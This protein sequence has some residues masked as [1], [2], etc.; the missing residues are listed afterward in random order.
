MWAGN[1]FT[2]RG[3]VHSGS[4]KSQ[5]FASFSALE[6][7]T[8]VPREPKELRGLGTRAGGLGS[9][10]VGLAPALCTLR[11]GP[12]VYLAPQ[13]FSLLAPRIL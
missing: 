7:L 2:H 8:Q 9:Q 3:R 13:T 1:A 6:V 10:G 5:I 11:L 12:G 4:C